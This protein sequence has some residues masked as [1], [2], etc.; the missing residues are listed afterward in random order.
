L[1]AVLIK[2]SALDSVFNIMAY[3]GGNTVGTFMALIRDA[4]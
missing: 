3:A 1:I 2:E 4:F